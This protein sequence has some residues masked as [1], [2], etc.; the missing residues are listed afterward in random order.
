MQK[1]WLVLF[2]IGSFLIYSKRSRFVVFLPAFFLQRLFALFL[3]FTPAFIFFPFVAHFVPFLLVGF[4]KGG[5]DFSRR[6]I[7]SA[8]AL[9]PFSFQVYHFHLYQVFNHLLFEPAARLGN[10]F[11]KTQSR[12]DTRLFLDQLGFQIQLLFVNRLP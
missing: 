4:S 7:K 3:L 12:A 6:P 5:Y 2:S 10:F 9:F 11:L 8:E 1:P